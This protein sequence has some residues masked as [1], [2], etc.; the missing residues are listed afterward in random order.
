MAKKHLKADH[1]SLSYWAMKIIY[2]TNKIQI[3]GFIPNTINTAYIVLYIIGVYVCVHVHVHVSSPFTG[4]TTHHRTAPVHQFE[5]TLYF[6]F[7]WRKITLYRFKATWGKVMT[8]SFTIGKSIPLIC[9][10][11]QRLLYASPD[12]YKGLLSL[13]LLLFILFWF[14]SL[15]SKSL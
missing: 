4:E 8:R 12:F 3:C 10:G 11:V 5:E 6:K 9:S 7:R 13:L 14:R 15:L 1:Q 2:Q